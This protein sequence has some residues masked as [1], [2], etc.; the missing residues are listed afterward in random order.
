MQRGLKHTS[1][2]T[3][4]VVA[5]VTGT[6]LQ[7][8]EPKALVGHTDPAYFAVYTTDGKQLVTA[9]FDKTLRLWDLN[10]LTSIRTMTGHT[11][12]VL[13]AALSKDGAR[14][15]SGSL[16]NSVRIWDMPIRTPIHNQAVHQGAALVAVSPDGTWVVTAGQD[17]TIKIWNAADRALI[18]EIGGLPHPIT[19]LALRND[20][21]QVAVA[22]VAGFVRFFNPNDGALQ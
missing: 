19:K 4:V 7:A 6:G 13:S 20:K 12:L 1:W 5:F 11:G 2:M 9:G 22:D 10:S 15:V 17:K 18:K 16:D 8:A 21:A 3:M 14:L